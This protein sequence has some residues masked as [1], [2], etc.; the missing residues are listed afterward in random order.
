MG[1]VGVNMLISQGWRCTVCLEGLTPLNVQSEKEI[2]AGASTRL[3]VSSSSSSCSFTPTKQ[4]VT[5]KTSNRW[6]R[7][8]KKKFGP[9]RFPMIRCRSRGWV[10]WER[11]AATWEDGR[12]ER[13]L[14]QQEERSTHICTTY[15]SNSINNWVRERQPVRLCKLTHSVACQGQS[16]VCWILTAKLNTYWGLILLLLLHL[17]TR[18]THSHIAATR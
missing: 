14:S 12:R 15:L 18:R 6:P 1:L 11:A 5:V 7:P 17:P 3:K 9:P 10:G 2:D 16:S 4:R 13:Q 8:N